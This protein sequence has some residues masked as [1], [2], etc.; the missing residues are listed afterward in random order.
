MALIKNESQEKAIEKIDGP[1]ILVSCPGS[2]KTTTLVRRIKN[3][4]SHG[5]PAKKILM[6]T[7]AKAAATDMESRYIKM[8]GENP[9]ITFRTIHG[10]C[11]DIL[12]TEKGYQTE[13]L[14]S[15][16]DKRNYVFNSIKFMP[17]V[18]D[19]GDLTNQ[20]VTEISY[21]KNRDM[22]MSGYK[23][24]SCEKKYFDAIYHGYEEYKDSLKKFDFDD[25]LIHCRDLLMT[26]K[27]ALKRWQSKYDYI[28]VDEFQDTNALQRDILY[29]LA[30]EKANICAV[31]DDDQSIY[32]FRGA[33]SSIMMGFEDDFAEKNAEMIMMSTNYRSAQKIIDIADILIR[34]NKKRFQ[35][36][37]ISQ[38]G[39][40]GETGFVSYEIYK[41]KQEE[42]EQVADIIQKKHAAGTPY[43]DMAILYRNNKQAS[44]PVQVLSSKDIPFECVEK[45]TT[46]YDGW[47]FSDICAYI[48]LSLGKNVGKNMM[49]ILNRPNR[50]F[51]QKDFMDKESPTGVVPFETTHML[52]VLDKMGFKKGDGWKYNAAEDAIFIWIN[53]FG[54][55]KVSADTPPSDLFERLVGRRGVRYD[56]YLKDSARFRNQD[57]D[58]LMDELNELRADAM[59]FKTIGEWFRHVSQVKQIV[60]KK[61]HDK[62]EKGVQL[63]TMHKSKG[64]EWNT[65][66]VISINDNVIPGKKA[67]TQDD[68]EEERRLLYVAMTRAKDN[69][70]LSC[71]GGESSF[72]RS[73]IKKFKEK[74][75]PKIK[76]KLAGAP[77]VH[78]KYGKGKVVSYAGNYVTISFKEG[79]KKFLFPDAFQEGH[80]RYE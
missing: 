10:L 67:D 33:D 17:W 28:Q 1:V 77:V 41:G 40:D 34:N 20:L 79:K 9:G 27:A 70:Y 35:K 57:E 3:I 65:V 32:R 24:E 30:G 80:L 72:M 46:I 52:K 4:V 75:K 37:F 44:I 29:Q 54:P 60:A 63:M 38:R 7:F 16:E 50:Y 51:H 36:D 48:N 66:F 71:S 5:V 69:L 26:D 43:E 64:M 78:T 12:Q 61:M 11:L 56:K 55:G 76:K 59:K 2:G 15:E 73:T 58:E 39:T 47:I 14:F 45:V 18:N 13:D 42:M 21:V 31:G 74:E 53:N 19:V 8:F 49:Q 23:P 6:V 62:K 22:D 25:M 68:L